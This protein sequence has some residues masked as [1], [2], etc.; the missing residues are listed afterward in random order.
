[1]NDRP[2]P[3]QLCLSAANSFLSNFGKGL[4]FEFEGLGVDILTYE[5]G[6]LTGNN[7][8]FIESVRGCGTLVRPFVVSQMTAARV[9][10]AELEMEPY[11]SSC[12]TNFRHE[13]F[14]YLV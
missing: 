9:A 2:I 11:G 3:G 5:P 13:M 7:K 12:G 8:A 6:P 14:E 10:L 1:M 4:S